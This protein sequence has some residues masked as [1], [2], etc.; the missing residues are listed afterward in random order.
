MN[1]TIN[2]KEMPDQ[3][4]VIFKCNGK[5]V[6]KMRNELTV[7]MVSPLKETFELA[8]LIKEYGKEKRCDN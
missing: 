1:N 4:K 8:K 2:L 6:G 5:P 7:D 3:A